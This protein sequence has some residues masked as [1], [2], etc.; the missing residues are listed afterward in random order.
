MKS[1]KINKLAIA[2]FWSLSLVLTNSS[3][4]AGSGEEQ[5]P[6]GPRPLALGGAYTAIATGPDA[7]FWNPAGLALLRT[8]AVRG[9]TA[10][11]FGL[12]IRD[13]TF[14][15]VSP[16]GERLGLGHVVADRDLL[17]PEW[18]RHGGAGVRD[19]RGPRAERARSADAGSRPARAGQDARR[20]GA[21]R[22]CQVVWGQE[23]PAGAA[24]YT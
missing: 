19:Q 9:A 14:T 16:I 4:L 21:A 2:F 1:L 17:R 5:I 12:G 18:P 10:N 23:C 22:T 13:N 20:V 24:S 15:L 11:L 6:V 7:V 8:S 3:V